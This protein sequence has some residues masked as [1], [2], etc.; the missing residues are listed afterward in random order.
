[1]M[2]K[3]RYFITDTLIQQVLNKIEQTKAKK[4]ENIILK[5]NGFKIVSN[6]SEMLDNKG[7]RGKG[8]PED[9]TTYGIVYFKYAPITYVKVERSFSSYKM[10]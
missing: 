10:Y 5:N 9:L 2:N 3:R 7:T 4:M 8:I 6:I 1:M